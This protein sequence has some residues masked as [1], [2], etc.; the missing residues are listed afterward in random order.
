MWSMVLY[1]RI[2]AA[3]PNQYRKNSKDVK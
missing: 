1:M 2:E 3:P